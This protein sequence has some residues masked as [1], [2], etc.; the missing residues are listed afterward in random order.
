MKGV[1]HITDIQTFLHCTMI[2]PAPAQGKE[3]RSCCES[4]RA[5]LEG[6]E[7]SGKESETESMRGANCDKSGEKY[8]GERSI[9]HHTDISDQN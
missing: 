5:G 4:V 2:T 6:S 1:T 3:R 8:V 7:Q 9:S